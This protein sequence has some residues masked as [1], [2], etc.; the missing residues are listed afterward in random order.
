MNAPFGSTASPP[1][2]LRLG[3]GAVGILIRCIMTGAEIARASAV[4]DD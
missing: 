3:S 1:C 2:T 4:P